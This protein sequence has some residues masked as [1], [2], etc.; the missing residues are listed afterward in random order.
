MYT[1]KGDSG[2]TDSATGQRIKKYNPVIE[3]EGTM[4]ELNSIIGLARSYIKFQDI[5][6]DLLRVQYDIFH[7]GEHVLVRGEA[8]RLRDDAVS[9]LEERTNNYFK[10]VGE[11]KLFVVPGGSMESAYLQFAR[12]VT[13]RAERL[14]VQLN[15]FLPVDKLILQYM[16]RLSSLLFAMALVANKRVGFKEN[17]FPWPNP[18]RKAKQ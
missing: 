10:E 11:I 9:W 6:E 18:E 7:L 15:D 14:T 3:W 1:R 17:I 4:D 16:N 12:T 8:R 5:T 13:R 2:D